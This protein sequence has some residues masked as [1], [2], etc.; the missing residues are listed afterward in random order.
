MIIRVN[1]VLNNFWQSL[2][3]DVSTTFVSYLKLRA[4]RRNNSQH[5]WANIVGSCCVRLHVDK[6]LT[7][8]KLWCKQTQHV[9]SYNVA[10]CWPTVSC[11]FASGRNN[12]QQ[13]WELFNVVSVCLLPT[14]RNNMQ[15]GGHTDAKCDIQ[16]CWQ[17]LAN[18]VASVCTDKLYVMNHF[19]CRYNSEDSKPMSLIRFD[20][21]FITV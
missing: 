14:T 7:G 13:C 4:N 16:R 18:S 5:R 17:S 20:P 3:F 9:A 1:V 15:L 8:F 10:S 2:S 19:R 6:S 11:P 21:S 12:F